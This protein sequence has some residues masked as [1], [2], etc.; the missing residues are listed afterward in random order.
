MVNDLIQFIIQFLL[1]I[2]FLDSNVTESISEEIAFALANVAVS[3]FVTFRIILLHPIALS[4]VNQKQL[5][6]EIYMKCVM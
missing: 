3:T 5:I 2:I 4:P 1:K 6:I